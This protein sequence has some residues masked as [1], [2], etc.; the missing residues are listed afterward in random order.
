MNILIFG[1]QGSGKSTIGKYIA[2]K[3]NV[4]FVA[5]GDIFRKLREED[6]ELGKLVREKINQGLLVPDDKTMNIVN[7]RLKEKDTNNGFILDGAPRNMKQVGLLERN[8]DLIVMVSLKKEEATRRLLN[9][10]RHDDT[11][12]KIVNRISWYED[13][14]KPVID[15]YKEKGVESIKVD[16]TLSE[17]E[18]KKSVD[19]L[20]KEFKRN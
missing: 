10:G 6:S 8:V 14:T 15:Y 3:L 11:K 1:V 5:T 19:D 2:E 12:E 20:F 4:S 18:V 17:E 7:E 9:R 13:Q 16:N